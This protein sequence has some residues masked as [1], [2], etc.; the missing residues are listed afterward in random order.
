MRED[1]TY[2]ESSRFFIFKGGIMGKRRGIINRNGQQQ[3][4]SCALCHLVT[5]VGSDIFAASKGLV[6]PLT[7]QMYSSLGGLV[8][9]VEF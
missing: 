6:I 1:L 7:F 3:F 8:E 2:M 9:T 5:Q 4:L